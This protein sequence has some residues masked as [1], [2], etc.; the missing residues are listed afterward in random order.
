MKKNIAIVVHTDYPWKEGMSYRV[1]NMAKNLSRYYEVTVICPIL[2]SSYSSISET[3]TYRILRFDLRIL[4]KLRENRV[5]FRI[6]F[7]GI[8]AMCMV[9]VRR[10]FPFQQA[11]SLVQ[12]E[13]QLGLLP[14]RVLSVFCGAKLLVDD[15]LSQ[16]KYYREHL[17]FFEIIFH[18]IETIMVKQCSFVI[19][20]TER[21]AQEVKARVHFDDSKVKLVPNG[22][23]KVYPSPV[24]K[25]AALSTRDIVFVGS[26]Y[27]EQNRRAV[28]NL[29]EIFPSVLSDVG[30][31]RL[32]IIGGPLDLLKNKLVPF[33][34]NIKNN[35]LILGYLSETEKEKYL[36]GASVCALP[37]D[38]KDSLI[39]GVR[40]KALDFLSYGKILISTPTGIEGISGVVSGENVIVVDNLELFKKYLIDVL[41]YPEKY[42]EVRKNSLK[43]ASTYEW[44]NILKE[45]LSAIR[46]LTK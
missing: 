30:N 19:A 37:F 1:D 10:K 26:M 11:I 20:T 16:T 22:V 41:K 29:I 39:G 42:E 17:G 21:V 36:V 38:R 13:Q 15:L 45:Y 40:L 44:G 23:A 4:Q 3:G 43:L 14:S 35:V 12:S 25:F 18:A 46:E 2:E 34:E 24:S 31:A 33:Q 9:K 8:F 28:N 7:V 27:S 6:L 5:L 32:V